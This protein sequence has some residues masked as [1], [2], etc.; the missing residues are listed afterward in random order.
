MI[1]AFY[2]IMDTYDPTIVALLSNP[3]TMIAFCVTVLFLL[4]SVYLCCASGKDD[5]VEEEEEEGDDGSDNDVSSTRVVSSNSSLLRQQQLRRRVVAGDKSIPSLPP[6]S[7]KQTGPPPQEQLQIPPAVQ[8]QVLEELHSRI[9]HDHPN[10]EIRTLER[11]ETVLAE[12]GFLTLWR[13]LLKTYSEKRGIPS[14]LFQ[15]M[16][17]KFQLPVQDS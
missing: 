6:S 14:S 1:L 9:S 7:P 11:W 3:L 15:E 4:F 12:K 8:H 2:I 5:D 10:C 16:A 13:G 17:V